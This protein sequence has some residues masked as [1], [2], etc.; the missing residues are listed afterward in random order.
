MW[1][2]HPNRRKRKPRSRTWSVETLEIRSL[3]SAAGSGYVLEG[4]QWPN[5]G[6]ITYSI[7][8]DGTQWD[9]GISNL[10][11]VMN[12]KFGSG[13]WQYQIAKALA[14][15]ESVANINIS[16]TTDSGAPFNTYGLAQG[17]PNFGDIRIAGYNFNNPTVAAQTYPPPPDGWTAA[18]DSEIN[19]AVNYSIGSGIDLYSVVLHEM[20]HALGLAESPD[21]AAVMYQQYQGVRTGL[22]SADIAGI[23]SLYGARTLDTYQQQGIGTSFATAI[24]LNGSLTAAGQATVTG[25]SLGSIGDVEYYLVQAPADA[26]AGTTLQAEAVAAGQSMLSPKI[27]ILNASQSL[28]ASQANPSGFSDNVG[29]AVTNVQPGAFYYVAVTGATNNVFSVGTYELGINFVG[30]QAP[31][32]ASTPVA[33]TPV[34]VQPAN[35]LPASD[36]PVATSPAPVVASTNPSP[37]PTPS[38]AGAPYNAGTIAPFGYNRAKENQMLTWQR[39]MARVQAQEWATWWRLSHAPQTAVRFPTIA[40]HPFF[41]RG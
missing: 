12:A 35:P 28:L 16:P 9:H 34:P 20:G 27:E 3:L 26:G 36:N 14:T 33:P 13:V 40:R 37:T 29:A 32:A 31:V 7:V 4:T 30:L 22:N 2:H 24:N 17:D 8:P 5:P 39:I 11:A 23:Q 6:H 21:P 15:W 41:R 25:V 19:T 38:N 18:G 1:F 10:N